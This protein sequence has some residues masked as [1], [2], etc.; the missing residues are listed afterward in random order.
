[1]PWRKLYLSMLTNSDISFMRKIMRISPAKS[2]LN[3]AKM[4]NGSS[5]VIS[6]EESDKI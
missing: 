4:S 2:R 1:M 6:P 3:N 5:E